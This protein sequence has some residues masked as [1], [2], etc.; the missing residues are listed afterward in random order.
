M[1]AIIDL[2]E[3]L[4][5]DMGVDLRRADIGMAKEF[6]YRAEV[7]GRFEEVAGKGM[8]QHVRVHVLW[9]TLFGSALT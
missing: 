6:L 5:V 3:M 7:A 1:S 8:P 2:G 9:H 4:K